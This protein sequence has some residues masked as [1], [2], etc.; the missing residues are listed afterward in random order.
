MLS[1]RVYDQLTYLTQN[2]WEFAFFLLCCRSIFCNTI[3]L[4]VKNYKIFNYYNILSTLNL[5]K[6]SILYSSLILE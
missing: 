1:R 5:D 6:F 4:S 2:L 3:S